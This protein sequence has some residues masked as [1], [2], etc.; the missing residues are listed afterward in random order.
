MIFSSKQSRTA[1]SSPKEQKNNDFPLNATWKCDFRYNET[2]IQFPP[3]SNLKVTRKYSFLLKATFFSS[4]KPK[5]M[6][7]AL[8]QLKEYDFLFNVT[9]KFDF[10]L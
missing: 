2:Q 4:N 9:L 7:L 5:N 10:R 3:Q 6:K 8:R 1:V